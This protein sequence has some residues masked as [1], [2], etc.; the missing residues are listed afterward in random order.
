MSSMSIEIIM[1]ID[2]IMSIRLLVI[3][4][5]SQSW[6]CCQDDSVCTEQF[7]SIELYCL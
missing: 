7:N 3:D 1:V 6:Y 2:V 4:N 5:R